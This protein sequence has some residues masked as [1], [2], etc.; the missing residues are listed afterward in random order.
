MI[1]L[2]LRGEPANQVEVSTFDCWAQAIGTSRG[3]RTS[4]IHCLAED[5]AIR[6]RQFSS[7]AWPAY[8]R[9]SRRRGHERRPIRSIAAHTSEEMLLSVCPAGSFKDRIAREIGLAELRRSCASM[10]SYH[11]AIGAWRGRLREGRV[12][13]TTV[14]NRSH[15]RPTQRPKCGRSEDLLDSYWP[16]C[17]HAELERLRPARITI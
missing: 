3:E 5:R 8:R 14:P 15:R 6:C 2:L 17:R 9:S 16:H 11:R 12:S 4:K 1:V 7:L 10:D 13:L